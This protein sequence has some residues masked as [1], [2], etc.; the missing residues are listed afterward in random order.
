M[1]A[2]D[3][4]FFG[5]LI[6]HATTSEKL[7]ALTFDD[8][9]G[10]NTDEILKILDNSG[11]KATFFM[12]GKAMEDLPEETKKIAD[13]GNQLGNHSY[14]HQRMIFKDSRF[15][16]DEIEKTDKLIRN[17]G[18]S[19]EIF[20]RPPYGKKL[21]LLPYYLKSTNRLTITWDIAPDSNK[22]IA[23]NKDK[24]VNYTLEKVKPGS[25][26][27]LHPF[28]NSEAKA[29]LPLIISKLRDEG[30]KLVTISD[31]LKYQDK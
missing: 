15:Y 3:F 22:D 25:I 28:N 1:N 30:Y 18:Y 2:T 13:S 14:S 11:A 5:N 23:K 7:V 17:S 27:L 26:I 24:I 4:Q 21:F 8:A 6:A 10:K 9:P 29:A 19:G 16:K 12:V 31:L 20:F